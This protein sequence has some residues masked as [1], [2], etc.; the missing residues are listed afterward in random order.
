VADR[1]DIRVL[2][3]DAPTML[4]DILEQ[5]IS[6]ERDMEVIPEPG[7]SPPTE[8]PPGSP[9]VVVVCVSDDGHGEGARALLSRWPQSHVLMI[10]SRGQ[11]VFRYEL[12]PQRVDLGEMSPSQLADAIRAAVRPERK[13]D[14]QR[15]HA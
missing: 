12:L 11:R 4:R 13:P 7:P 6:S 9:D 8:M 1:S 3:R 15:G 14:D 2:I 5:V 10:T